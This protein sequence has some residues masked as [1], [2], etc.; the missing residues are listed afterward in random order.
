MRFLTPAERKTTRKRNVLSHLARN[1]YG[2]FVITQDIV[3]KNAFRKRLHSID[4]V[5]AHKTL[6]PDRTGSARN[7]FDTA[8]LRHRAVRDFGAHEDSD[9]LVGQLLKAAPRPGPIA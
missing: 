9:G 6:D 4:R 1:G 3:G 2:L 5:I 8:T 7:R